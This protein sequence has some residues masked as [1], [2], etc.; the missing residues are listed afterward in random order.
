M[1]AELSC[2]RARFYLVKTSK[3]RCNRNLPNSSTPAFQRWY[4]DFSGHHHRL[5]QC[6]PAFLPPQPKTK[7][8]D[9]QD[10]EPMLLT[11]G[12]QLE[13]HS[14]LQDLHVHLSI[15]MFTSCMQIHQAKY[16]NSVALCA[17]LFVDIC[18]LLLPRTRFH[19]LFD[20]CSNL[21]G[22]T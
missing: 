21:A 15:S 7:N 20:T 11:W 6:Q 12:S 22:Q 4:T 8:E 13:L 2:H 1:C 18:F 3:H 14:L 5:P 19:L 16:R 17:L 10:F 9:C